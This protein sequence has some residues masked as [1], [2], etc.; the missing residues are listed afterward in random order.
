MAL[1]FMEH[2]CKLLIRKVFPRHMIV[3]S[4]SGMIIGNVVIIFL[5]KEIFLVTIGLKQHFVTCHLIISESKLFNHFIKGVIY[6]IDIQDVVLIF[7]GI[8][9][10]FPIAAIFVGIIL[11]PPNVFDLSFSSL[12][13]FFRSDLIL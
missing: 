13:N 2:S 1:S 6:K 7:F 11:N 3:V 5:A 4:V 10:L 8:G 12:N 9:I